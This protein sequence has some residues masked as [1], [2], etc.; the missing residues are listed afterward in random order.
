MRI[1]YVM[2]NVIKHLIEGGVG[3]KS[4]SQVRLWQELGETAHLFITSPDDLNIA[5]DSVFPFQRRCSPLPGVEFV[6]HEISRSQALCRLLEHV[7]AYRPDIIYLRFGSFAYPLHNLFDIAPVVLELNTNDIEEFRRRGALRYFL[8]LWTRKMLLDRASGLV[9]ISH[10]IA[11]LPS[12]A[13][14]HKP[15]LVLGNGIDFRDYQPFP[16]PRNPLPRL[17]FSGTPQLPWH[18]VDKLIFLARQFPD[19]QVDVIGYSSLDLEI[20][21]IP[22][23]I[24]FHGFLAG[25]EY[26]QILSKA[27]VGV[28]TLALHRNRMEEGSPLKVREYLAYGLPVILGYQDTDLNNITTDFILRIPNSK[29]NVKANANLIRDFSYRMM[30][31]RA[32]RSLFLPL[33]NQQEK[34]RKRLTYFTSLLET[35]W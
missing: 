3:N 33:I 24:V 8:N 22:D 4:I 26:R 10:E 34:E 18:G 35:E 16:P 6:A 29:D 25:K 30:G 14:F 23:N 13:E 7:A 17:V 12:I 27:D 9:A 32:D 31:R 19:L 21:Q 20:K 11:Q 28:G 5:G 1:A 2:L 15:A